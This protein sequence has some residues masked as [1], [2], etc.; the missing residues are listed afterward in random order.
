M[1]FLALVLVASACQTRKGPGPQPPAG[2]G[3]PGGTLVFAAEQYPKCLNP[4]TS[5]YSASWLHYTALL[6]T[7]AQL[8]TLDVKNNYVASDLVQ[9]VPSV[10]NG[11]VTKDPFTVTYELNPKAVWDDGTPISGQDV[12]FT[13]QA[14]AKS[15]KSIF[16][17]TGFDKITDVAVDGNKVTLEF[18]EP[19]APWKDLMGGGGEYV[20]K[21]SAFGGNPEISDALQREVPF[22]G[23]PFKLESF[24]DSEM[25]LVRN[26]SYYGKKALLDRV[27]FR[28][29]TDTNAETNAFRT[30]EIQAFF[31][32][33]TTELRKLIKPVPGGQIGVK[34]GTVFEGL[35]FNLD[36]FPVNDRAVRE[37]LLYGLTR[38]SAINTVVRPIDS[39]ATVNHCLWSV[40]SLA[41][42]KWCNKDFPTEPNTGRAR[43]ALEGAGWKRGP[44]GI[45]VKDGQRLVIPIA[46]TAGNIG[47]ENF[48]KSL[49]GQA[50]QIGIEIKIDNSD[51]TTLFQT[52]L[53]SRDFVVAMFAQVATPDPSV[54]NS[55]ASDQIPSKDSPG[56]QNYYGW[57]DDE[58]TALMKA[59]DAEVD[60]EKRVE[61][62]RSLGKMM[63]RDIISIPLYPKP[64]ILVWNSNRLGG[65]FDFNAGQLAFS[66]QL[67]TW[68]LRQR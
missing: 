66:G 61:Q 22:A 49:Q 46:T 44:D 29:I 17:K 4:V 10:E 36:K 62:Y 65:D 7:M 33:P 54:T 39:K 5:C 41:G 30:G 35:W 43:R 14:Y 52:R 24:T 15:A 64:Q 13:W 68:F 37:A 21:T 11:L 47:R 12:R 6:P 20:L 56:G 2:Q 55:L 38:Q 48:Q 16:S 57:R 63:A 1:L 34:A 27:V 26:E 8:L 19:Y 32:Q 50:K 28:K 67:R 25:V 60:E 23:G 9:R 45:Y 31:P 18:S 59:S 51:P 53:P 58:A 42:G 40:P 3:K